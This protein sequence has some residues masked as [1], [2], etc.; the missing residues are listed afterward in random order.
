MAALCI[1]C[2]VDTATE[3]GFCA[4]CNAERSEFKKKLKRFYFPCDDGNH[5]DYNADC[6]DC[7]GKNGYVWYLIF[8]HFL[9]GLEVPGCPEDLVKSGDKWADIIEKYK[10]IIGAMKK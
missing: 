5:K 10:E 1:K 3:T 9:P 8:D 4:D 6:C 7:I 2:E